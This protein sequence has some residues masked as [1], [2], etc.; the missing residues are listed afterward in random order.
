MAWFDAGETV[1]RVAGRVF[2]AGDNV[3]CH[4][5]QSLRVDVSIARGSRRWPTARLILLRCRTVT[6]RSLPINPMSVRRPGRAHGDTTTTMGTLR[7]G[8]LAYEADFA[9]R[10]LPPERAASRRRLSAWSRSWWHWSSSASACWA[11]PKLSGFWPT[12]STRYLG[13][14]VTGCAAGPRAWASGQ[15]MPIATI[16]PCFPPLFSLINFHPYHQHPYPTLPPPVATDATL[17]GRRLQQ[18]PCAA[19]PL[20]RLRMCK[21]GSRPS[22]Q[23]CRTPTGTISWPHEQTR[24][25]A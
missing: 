24:S 18:P 19:G 7:G 6:R 25:V 20:G 22:M 12:A 2:Q 21:R 3:C 14:A 10:G 15:C 13:P 23:Y 11:S 5:P 8:N 4:P 9:F 1:L 16:G 17:T